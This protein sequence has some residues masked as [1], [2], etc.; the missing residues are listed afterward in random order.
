[1]GSFWR[2]AGLTLL[3]FM[4]ACQGNATTLLPADTPVII[5]PLD[6][7]QPTASETAT[8]SPEPTE[9]PSPIPPTQ[10]PEPTHKAYPL[11]RLVFGPPVAFVNSDGTGLEY[12]EWLVNFL[13]LETETPPFVLSPDGRYVVF[14][15]FAPDTPPC[16]APRDTGCPTPVNYY[17]ADFIEETVTSLP[18]HE[19]ISWA[20]DSRHLVFSQS[21]PLFQSTHLFQ[22]DI[23]TN[24]TK[25]LTDG[26]E[27]DLYPAWSPDGQRIAFLRKPQECAQLSS[28]CYYTA[29]LYVMN[30]DGSNLR[31]LF[32]SFPF[33]DAGDNTPIWSPNGQWIAVVTS[34]ADL[35]IIDVA[36]GEMRRITTR[37]FSPAWSPDSQQLAFV[38]DQD[39]NIEIYKV[40]IDGTGLVNLTRNP[41][42]DFR[43]VWSPSGNF[44]AFRSYRDP[45][46][47]VG[48][49]YVMNS[50]G[51]NV[52][53]LPIVNYGSLGQAWL[54]VTN[55]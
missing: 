35:V 8:P 2:K 44:I 12:P 38:T 42:S 21:T 28:G 36:N 47:Q 18:A 41:A 10:T 46:L 9:T 1:M 33:G 51:G 26:P 19:G 15:A 34:S 53:Q 23:V 45:L 17:L 20:P 30:P 5:L 40:F 25:Q 13:P 11:E 14:V 55:P 48:Y 37:G 31:L 22:I 50:D 6:T 49:V 16:D 27:A 43:P 54:P 39:G 4:A 32:D 24:E 7:P 29:S 3:M 52:K